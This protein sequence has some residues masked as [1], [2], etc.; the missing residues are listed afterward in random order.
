[1]L[2]DKVVTRK[3]SD[4]SSS[5]VD[6]TCLSNTKIQ[7]MFSSG[8]LATLTQWLLFQSLPNSPFSGETPRLTGRRCLPWPSRHCTAPLTPGKYTIEVPSFLKVIGVGMPD[9]RRLGSLTVE[10]FAT[11]QEPSINSAVVC[12]LSKVWINSSTQ[13]QFEVRGSAGLC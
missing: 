1:M 7:I 11:I 3:A 4:W 10:T 6:P 13:I 2:G 9:I 5:Y 12:I 8:L